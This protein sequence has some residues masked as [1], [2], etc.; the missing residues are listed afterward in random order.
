MLLPIHPVI[1]TRTSYGDEE[2]SLEEVGRNAFSP[3]PF[4]D[5]SQEPSHRGRGG[6]SRR[7]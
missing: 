7:R 3:Y 6:A 1:T 4:W 2:V 5:C